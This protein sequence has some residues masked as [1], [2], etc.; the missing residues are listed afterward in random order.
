MLVLEK[1][2]ILIDTRLKHIAMFICRSLF[3]H[4]NYPLGDKKKKEKERY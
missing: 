1:N 2:L 3:K 4:Q